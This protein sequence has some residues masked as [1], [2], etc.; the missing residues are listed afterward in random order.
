MEYLAKGH[1]GIVYLDYYNGKK[2]C[3]KIEK[4]GLGRVKNEAKFLKLL[5]NIGIGPKF[6]SYK[7]GKLKYYYVPGVE[8]SKKFNNKIA[9][10]VFKQ[11]YK[12]DKLGI[13]KFEMHHPLKHVLIGKKIVMIDFEKCKF[14]KNPKNVTG[15]SQFVSRKLCVKNPVKLLR[16]YKKNYSLESFKKII[17]YFKL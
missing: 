15:F 11:C 1:R 13:D 17:S 7:N 9:L 8:I 16:D 6:I 3:V 2:I 4:R 10:G 14:S 12:I 5:N